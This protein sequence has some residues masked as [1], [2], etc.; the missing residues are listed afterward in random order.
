MELTDEML[1]IESLTEQ[2]TEAKKDEKKNR[3]EIV[4]LERELAEALTR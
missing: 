4:R 2:L 3:D 1:E